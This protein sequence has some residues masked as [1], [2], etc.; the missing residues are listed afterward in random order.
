MTNQTRH[1][2]RQEWSCLRFCFTPTCVISN[3]IRDYV[4]SFIWV[5]INSL[6]RASLFNNE[7]DDSYNLQPKQKQCENR[8]KQTVHFALIM[9]SATK[10][11]VRVFTSPIFMNITCI[12]TSVYR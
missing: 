7:V 9:M 8:K 10:D 2:T 4:F 3:S 11:L 6:T 12:Q 1:Q 5:I